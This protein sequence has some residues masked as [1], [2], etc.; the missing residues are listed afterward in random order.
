MSVAHKLFLDLPVQKKLVVILWLFLVVVIGLL[1]LSYMTIE[2]L[3]AAR[4]YVGGEGLW[5]KA[6]KQ[7]I[8]DLLCY[9]ISH[10][11]RD[12]E[13]YQEALLVPLGDKQARLELEKPVPDMSVV[14]RVLTQGRNNPEDV[15]GMAAMFRHCRHLNHMSEAI[16][17][18]SQGD[19]LIEQLQRLGGD[20][21]R[22]ISS[23]R[24]NALRIAEIARQVD[25]LGDQLTPLEDRFSYAL[26]AG[27]RQA[28]SLFLLVTFSATAISLIG[29]LL[30]TAFI[31]RHMRQTEQR[32]K[33]LIDTANDA[34]L[35]IDAETG[36]VLEANA[37]SSA[38]L[39]R[40]TREIV[41]T[42]AESI[43][44][45]SDHEAYRGMWKA[46]L[47]GTA[48]AGRE[49]HLIHSDGSALAVEVNASLTEFEGRK[50]VQGIF[51]DI[52]ERKR[53]E[54]EVRQTQKMEVVGRLVGGIAHDFNN[55][56]MVILTQIAKVHSLSS[57]PQILEHAET[58]RIAAEKAASLTKQLLAFGRRQ[59]LVLQVLDLNELLG[60]VNEMLSTLPTEQVQLMMAPSSQLLHVKVDPGKIEQVIMN[61]AVNACDAM[62]SGGV[63]KIRTAQVSRP[64]SEASVTNHSAPF[65]MV[66]MTDTGC[67]MDADTKAHLFEPFFTTKPI[68]EGTGLGLSTAYGIVKQ[69]G[70]TI[71][72]DSVPGEGT[73]FRVYLPIVEQP[74]SPRKAP[75]V[76]SPATTG[77]ETVLLAEDQSSIRTV[78]REFLESE[79]YKVLEAQNGNEALEIA[80]HYTGSID[81]LVTDV[82]MPQLRGIELATRLTEIDPGIC[83]ILMS[84]YSEDA[85]VENRLLSERNMTLIQKPFDP[86]ELALKIRASLNA[87][88]CSA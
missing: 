83:V 12:F 41:G 34:I 3:S 59:V 16:S 44:L 27:A 39:G 45:E 24:P 54:E 88:N 51:R 30:F 67:G 40:P 7:A 21:H 6:Q 87:R 58:V 84:G 23:E 9:S 86:E 22:E 75:K 69:S 85:L 43:I 80:K 62:P 77:S 60:E 48:V 55:L 17:I 25:V 49:L 4:A 53:L 72:V 57:Q 47:G 42:R 71:E 82:I 70:G 18:W 8:H 50:I 33:H 73:T 36:I 65:A 37:R 20:L 68:G 13:A 74:V 63:L 2:N 66:E 81:V 28:K 19:A 46:A 61:L 10:S 26:G 38:F 1:G 52:R 31:L 15:K 79:G 76:S 35:V 78:L 64:P 29:G 32:Y 11:E 56:L 14:R 5:S